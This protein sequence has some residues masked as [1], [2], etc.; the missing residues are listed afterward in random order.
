MKTNIKQFFSRQAKFALAFL[1]ISSLFLFSGCGLKQNNPQYKV[2]LEIWGVFDSSD[3]LEK[4]TNEYKKINPYVGE[5]KYRKFTVDSYKNDLINALASGQGPDIFLIGNTWLPSFG[6]KV[7]P[8]PDWL[9]GEKEFRDNFVDVAADD[10]LASGK[11]YSVPLSVDSLALYYNKD[12]LNSEGITRPPQTWEEF[13]DDVRKLTK[14][15]QNDNITQAGAAIGTAYNINRSV[16]ILTLLMLQN[17]AQMTND[18]NTEATFDKP[19]NIGGKTIRA[20]ETALDYYAQFAKRNS[21][22]Y[23]WNP[24]MHY[25]IDAFYEG[26]AAMMI[27]Y[28]WQYATIKS[29][30]SKL[31][32][33][34]APIPQLSSGNPVNYAN[35]WGLTVAKNKI[36]SDTLK[37]KTSENG[38][39]DGNY[40]KLRLHEAWQFLKY[41]TLKN[42]GSVTLYNGL[43]VTNAAFPVKDNPAEVYIKET[44][45]PAARRDLI[46]KQKNDPIL[47]PFAYG[48]LIAK[49]W[50]EAEPDAIEQILAETIDSVNLGKSTVY[51]SLKLAVSRV[52]QLMRK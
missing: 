10:F 17:G 42:N 52:T 36:L 34:V 46:E 18:G 39:N 8:A 6:D 11:I 20:G 29:K 45:K 25:S 48:N 14:I 19:L 44:G 38:L 21:S 16:D 32:F 30:N 49:S 27:N 15:D 37:A 9:L 5:I 2:D 4:I 35:Y 51:E 31:N 23:T 40:N 28:S 3:T 24:R 41:L 43:S 50:Y 13:N 7:E 47:S 12:I 1:T 33:G 22:V 26:T